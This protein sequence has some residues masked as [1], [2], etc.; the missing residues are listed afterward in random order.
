M[1]ATKH[2]HELVIRWQQPHEWA[3]LV[4]DLSTGQFA[5]THTQNGQLKTITANMLLQEGLSVVE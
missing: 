5:I 2:E 1:P 3:E 4:A